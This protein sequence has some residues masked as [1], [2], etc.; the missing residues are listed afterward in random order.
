MSR[1]VVKKIKFPKRTEIHKLYRHSIEDF[2]KKMEKIFVIKDYS[3]IEK[4]LKDLE[5]EYNQ[6]HISFEEQIKNSNV[7]DFFKKDKKIIDQF[8]KIEISDIDDSAIKEISIGYD[9]LKM[10]YLNS[11][12]NFS[13]DELLKLYIEN[14]EIKKLN[15]VH[16]NMSELENDIK[17]FTL[18]GEN[19]LTDLVNILND[20]NNNKLQDT[21]LKVDINKIP[22]N[23]SLAKKS[24]I[25]FI[26]G[27]IALIISII[28]F[29]LI[30]IPM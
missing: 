30:F 25:Y 18:N 16:D 23:K 26:L 17:N 19:D 24:N 14:N 11:K 13:T 6:S 15:L 7:T 8:K 1:E 2:A 20:V 22:V 4:Q 3:K 5:I 12:I 10:R 9:E 29:V 27:I 21:F 28:I